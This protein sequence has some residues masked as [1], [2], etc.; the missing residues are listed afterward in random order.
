MLLEL[1]WVVGYVVFQKDLYSMFS[2]QHVLTE[3]AL[4]ILGLEV[5]KGSIP[6]R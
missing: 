4:E 2:L 5:P 1:K 6:L 3:K